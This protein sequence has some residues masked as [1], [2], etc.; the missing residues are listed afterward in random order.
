MQ[1]SSFGASSNIQS[2]QQLRQQMFS[3]SDTDSSGAL[4]LEEF[5]AIGQN[6][7][8]GNNDTSQVQSRFSEL[9]TDGSGDLSQEEMEAA[10]PPMP[11]E[12]AQSLLSLQETDSETDS[13][14][15]LFSQADADSSGG[16]TLEEFTELGTLTGNTE[17]TSDQVSEMFSSLDADG[18]GEVTQEEMLAASP[19]PPPPPG[20]M[21]GA[22][23]SDPF[24]E[25]DADGDG[26]LSLEEFTAL[27]Q[28]TGHADDSS[29]QTSAIFSELDTNEDGY[30][31]QAELEAGKTQQN[32]SAAVSSDSESASDAATL[33]NSAQFQAMIEKY[34]ENMMAGYGSQSQNSNMFWAA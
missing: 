3:K 11:P 12:M 30:V 14:S 32:Q 19:P 5:T 17:T 27:G 23:G 29:E 7:P 21:G 34:M 16:L 28:S 1:I 18:D 6:M 2:F 24:S 20:G 15:D 31:S 9:D 8:S 26:S 4:S 10:K 33:S 13:I 25:A 22:S